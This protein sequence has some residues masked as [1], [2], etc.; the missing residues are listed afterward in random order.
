MSAMSTS[1]LAVRPT[2]HDRLAA[3]IAHAGTVAAWFLAPL[4]VFLVLGRE[5]RWAR[6]QALQ[7]LLW[8]LL[9]TVVSLATCGLAIPVFLVWHFIAAVKTMNDGDYEYPLV[10]EAARRV[11]YGEPTSA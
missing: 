5:N 11:V 1:T 4:V 9:G 2:S 3:C 6:Y 8:S 7:S 10:G